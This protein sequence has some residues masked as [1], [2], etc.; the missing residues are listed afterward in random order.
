MLKNRIKQK[1]L[2]NRP[3]RKPFHTNTKTIQQASRK[4]FSKD[5]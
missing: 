3:S 4:G 2:T 1:G 5:L